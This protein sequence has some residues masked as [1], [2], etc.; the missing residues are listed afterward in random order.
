MPASSAYKIALSMAP[1]TIEA[2]VDGG[3]RL[4]AMF[5]IQMTNDA[6]RPTVAFATPNI[7]PSMLIEW[8]PDVAAYTSNDP[9]VGGGLIKP[10]YQTPIAQGQTFFVTTGGGGD[11]KS[12]GPPSKI[13]IANT[14]SIPFTS[15]FARSFATSETPIPIYAAPLY[16]NQT[17]VA[18]PLPK[19]LLLFTTAAIKPGEMLESLAMR[20]L[21]AASYSSSLLVTAS[22]AQIRELSYDINLGWNWGSYSWAELVAANADFAKVLIERD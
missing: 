19:I 21:P 1:A 9:I 8:M 6:A 5:A 16:G 3:Y 13:S 12:G 22:Q 20:F 14:T 7:A 10:G 15:G 17:N 2:L 18:V 4:C 11:I